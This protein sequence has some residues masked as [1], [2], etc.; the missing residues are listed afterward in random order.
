MGEARGLDEIA[1]LPDG[2]DRLD[3]D[4]EPL[5]EP[6]HQRRVAPPAAAHQPA[7]RRLADEVQRRRRRL[8]GEGRQRRGAVGVRQRLDLARPAR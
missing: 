7:P 5:A 6:R 2:F 8:D 4:A 3:P 1:V